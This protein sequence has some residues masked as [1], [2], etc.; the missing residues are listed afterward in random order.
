MSLT[1]A[2]V[3]FYNSGYATDAVAVLEPLVRN[4]SAQAIEVIRALLA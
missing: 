4:G 3:V 2:A 1:V